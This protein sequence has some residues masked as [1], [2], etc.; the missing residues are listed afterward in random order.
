MIK[1]PKSKTDM[2]FIDSKCMDY[3]SNNNK[4]QVKNK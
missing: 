2:L 1:K 3:F 4:K